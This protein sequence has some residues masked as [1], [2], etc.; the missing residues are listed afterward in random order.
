MYADGWIRQEL[1]DERLENKLYVEPDHGNLTHDVP[2]RVILLSSCG[3]LLL[4][5]EETGHISGAGGRGQI[6]E[7]DDDAVDTCLEA[8]GLSGLGDEQGTKRPQVIGNNFELDSV[9]KLGF[10]GTLNRYRQ[11]NY[12]KVNW[13]LERNKSSVRSLFD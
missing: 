2:Q 13:S 4:V 5:D 8:G 6:I 10:V 12:S 7:L 1:C 9:R 3:K 11:G